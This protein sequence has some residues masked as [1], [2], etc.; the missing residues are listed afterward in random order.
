MR[1]AIHI[2]GAG[3]KGGT[4]S[5][6]AEPRLYG[7]GCDLDVCRQFASFRASSGYEITAAIIAAMADHIEELQARLADIEA[8]AAQAEREELARYRSEV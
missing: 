2:G 1:G 8:R 3:E 6:S 5:T 7:F 4:Y